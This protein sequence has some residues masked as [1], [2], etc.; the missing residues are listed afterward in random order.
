MF[1][2]GLAFNLNKLAKMGSIPILVGIIEI[3]GSLLT[4][5]L[6]GHLM[7]F[8]MI[9]S[10]F[11]GVML[12][13]SSTAVIQKSFEELGVKKEKYAQLV[14]A[15]LIIEDIMAIFMMVI[16]STVSVSSNVSGGALVL[17][18]AL[19]LC[20]LAV[21]L[22]LGIYIVPTLLSKVID[23]M[24]DEMVLILSLGLCF[25]MV[26]IAKA[27]EANGITP[28]GTSDRIAGVLQKYSLMVSD[29]ND[30]ASIISAM[31]M[32]KKRSADSIKF[33]LLHSI[34]DS[35]TQSINNEDIPRF[36]GLE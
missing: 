18:L 3:S 24:N 19:M 23:L 9:N 10:L 36:F 11:L 15:D 2:I 7:G 12:S 6:V 28:V 27:G 16:L 13:I 14:L 22:I 1:H 8:T 21:W 35:F 5:Y 30:L 4:G 17:N 32:D 33:V 26:M 34:G 29:S 25:G 31:N 20:Y